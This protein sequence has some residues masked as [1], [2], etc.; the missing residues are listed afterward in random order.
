MDKRLIS[1]VKQARVDLESALANSG[2][3]I[4]QQ[5]LNLR[6]TQFVNT[7][8]GIPQENLIGK[9]DSDW[10]HPDEAAILT[11]IKQKALNGEKGIREMFKSTLN[12]G[13]VGDIYYNDIRVEPMWE[14]GKVVGIYTVAIDITEFQNALI[15]LEKLN[16]RLLKHMEEML[17]RQPDQKVPYKKPPSG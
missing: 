1:Q 12:G 9:T 8:P 11:K 15:R 10:L 2:V 3:A 14:D 6:Y 7:H 16:G 4:S 5:D 17:G 13:K